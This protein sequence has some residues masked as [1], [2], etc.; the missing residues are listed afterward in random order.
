M[1]KTII[2]NNKKLIEKT[3]EIVNEKKVGKT[4][5]EFLKWWANSEERGM[6]REHLQSIANIVYSRYR[7]KHLPVYVGKKYKI[8][9]GGLT[10][11]NK[12]T[13]KPKSITI[14]VLFGWRF[15]KFSEMGFPIHAAS[16]E[17][18]IEVLAHELAHVVELAKNQ[19]NSHNRDFYKRYEEILSFIKKEVLNESTV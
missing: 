18:L 7:V 11:Y 15:V 4:A 16:Y 19:N 12:F 8:K 1:K 6:I 14:F 2:K 3:L 9:C 17:A 5:G 10:H 13:C